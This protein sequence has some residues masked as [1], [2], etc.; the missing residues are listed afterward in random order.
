M[1]LSFDLQSHSTHSDGALS[2]ADV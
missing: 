2:A 1:P